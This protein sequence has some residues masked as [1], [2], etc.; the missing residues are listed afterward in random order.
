MSK[1]VDIDRTTRLVI[2]LTLFG[3]S[4]FLLKNAFIFWYKMFS[5]FVYTKTFI[6]IDS[7][8]S[9]IIFTIVIAVTWKALSYIFY[10][11]KTFQKYSEESKKNEA[12]NV[13]DTK[14]SDIFHTIKN[15]FQFFFV[16]GL[17]GFL[18]GVLFKPNLLIS[19]S[20]GIL[21]S[22][23][24][25]III[26]I[27]NDKVKEIVKK[28]ENL[29]K[30]IGPYSFLIYILFIIFFVGITISLISTT[31]NQLVKVEFDNSS[32]VDLKL[33]LQNINLKELTITTENMKEGI[34]KS[35]VNISEGEIM[36]DLVEVFDDSKTN[37]NRVYLDK[38]KHQLHYSIN[39]DKYIKEG[40]N[41][42][43]IKIKNNGTNEDSQIISIKNDVLKKE[44]MIEFSEKSFEIQP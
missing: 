44:N 18:I 26:R 11:L 24:F 33:V 42:I 17:I 20:I 41:I 21:I 31:T 10:E 14:F 7:I 35:K 9:L 38:S 22:I 37:N 12:M 1:E 40:K 34:N 36:E 16:T 2:T 27:K 4:W 43:E 8:I 39:L 15:C 13:A 19:F 32:G 5:T 25:F 29:E 23:L 6:N 30:K 28:A 3:G